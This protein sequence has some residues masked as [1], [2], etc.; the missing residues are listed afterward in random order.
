M[1]VEMRREGG[2]GQREGEG[3][4]RQKNVAAAAAAAD[5]LLMKGELQ[6]MIIHPRQRSCSAWSIGK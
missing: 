4:G 1:L 3:R 2:R 6:I 5:N